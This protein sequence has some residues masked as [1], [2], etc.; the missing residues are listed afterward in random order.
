MIYRVI[1]ILFSKPLGILSSI[2]ALIFSGTLTLHA[3]TEYV[4]IQNIITVNNIKTKEYVIL[5]E[6]DFKPGDT[7]YL[8]NL[9]TRLH[10]NERRIKSIG[11]FNHAV[12]N[13]KNWNTD[14]G[15]CDIEIYVIEN[16]FIYPYFIFELADRNFNV[17]RRE[18][19]YSLKRV[20]YGVAGNHINLS[21]NK[22]KLKLK[23]QGGY[24]K[25]LEAYYDYPYLWGNWG[26]SAN[27]LYAES[28]EIPYISLGNKPI[29]LKNDN[30]TKI[31][32]LYKGSLGLSQR[33]NPHMVQQFRLEYNGF[34]VDS[35]VSKS[36]PMYLGQGK[37]AINYFY[38]DYILR[39]DQT[40]YPLYPLKGYRFE[41]NARKEGL[42]IFKDVNNAWISLN[43]EQHFRLNHDLI[44]SARIK[45]KTHFQPDPIAYVLS[46]AI[47]Y[48]NDFITGYQLYVM[49]GKHFMLTK[50]AL[51]YRIF[52]KDFRFKS[53][54]PNQ[55][56]VFNIQLF[57]RLNFDAGYSFDPE[58]KANNP[59]SNHIQVGYGPGFD[60]I[61]YNNFIASL[62]L[63]ITRQKEAGIFFSGGF[64]F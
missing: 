38:I 53:F 49:D 2:L 52:E 7:L 51:R 9:S 20:N 56:K 33:I 18:F 36:N 37:N 13:I 23:F 31:Q 3:Q 25:K 24:L 59:L 34:Q 29:F 5:Y 8:D 6:L 64:N 12:I 50:H 55:F 16:W 46:N 62:E 15:T 28:R 32:F 58:N 57:G 61:L 35:L 21:G 39:Y 22:D 60:L 63:G 27:V 42:G 10:T 40:V 41:F 44:F 26:L 14:L 54:M 45:F 47:G 1:S 43:L 17:W 11:L 4:V 30:D 19:N 48:K